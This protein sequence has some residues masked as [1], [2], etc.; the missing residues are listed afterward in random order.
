VTLIVALK[1][2][3][4]IVM[5][6]DSRG[7]YGDPRAVTA[8]NDSMIKLHQLSRHAG[9]LMA[10]DAGLGNQLLASWPGDRAAS[11]PTPT[12]MESFRQHIRNQYGAWFQGFAI[13]QVHGST[14]PVRPNLSFVIA[15]YDCDA[16]GKASTPTLYN[17][18]SLYDFAPVRLDHGFALDGIAQ[19]ALY[20]FNRLYR[21]G[22]STEKLKS[23][24]AYAITETASQDGKVG[25]PIRM[26]TISPDEGYIEI[27]PTDV[28]ALITQNESRSDALRRSFFGED[29][30]GQRKAG[31]GA[32]RP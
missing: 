10:G 8:Q 30:G 28:D 26:A 19:Y 21:D 31:T 7:T 29:D 17:L 14:L 4:G 1:G 22:Y 5:A 13:Q 15:G 9:L 32:N 2:L 12:L 6:A 20:L 23:L 24:A 11:I 3:D 25:G 18:S 16:T 27:P